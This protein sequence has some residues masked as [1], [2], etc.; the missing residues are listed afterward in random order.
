MSYCK[1]IAYY[2]KN[3]EECYDINTIIW[4]SFALIILLLTLLFILF[5]YFYRKYKNLK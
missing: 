2:Y 1:N 3:F 5:I 4:V